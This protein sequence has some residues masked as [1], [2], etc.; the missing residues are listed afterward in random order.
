[1]GW[2]DGCCG[3]P[4]WVCPEG[5]LHP[6]EA[7]F[8]TLHGEERPH[9]ER[10]LHERLG[11]RPPRVV[12]RSL[13]LMPASDGL[14]TPCLA[15]NVLVYLSDTGRLVAVDMASEST[16]F[17]AEDVLQASC[18]IDRGWVRAALRLQSGVRYRAWDVRDL[19]DGLADYTEVDSTASGGAGSNLL[20]LPHNLTRLHM[21][22]GLVRLVV[23]HDPV[24]GQL[25]ETYKETTGVWPGPWLIRRTANPRG[26]AVHDIDLRPQ[27]L[28]QVP[29][30]I[31][32]GILVIGAVRAGSAVVSGALAIPT[33][34]A[35]W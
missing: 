16:V 25:A 31:P 28:W 17:L 13:E 30:P 2:L 20:G 1:M 22:S 34:G 32:G 23:E 5:Q 26:P 7:N 21:G 29:V 14:S 9:P 4:A 35:H 27:D 24:E 11:G 15:G 3:L 19:R 8:C 18:R 10:M 33:L 6:I 12:R